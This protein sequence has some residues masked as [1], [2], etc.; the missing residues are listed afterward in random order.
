MEELSTKLG[1]DLRGRIRALVREEVIDN[2]QRLL[3]VL[4]VSLCARHR[5]QAVPALAYEPILRN[6]T[7]LLSVGTQ[8]TQHVLVGSSV[9][10]G[11]LLAC[12]V[13]SARASVNGVH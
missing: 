12:C 5:L 4:T 10:R 8:S 9:V 13:I 11:R 2:M 7:I 1:A 6:D 3:S